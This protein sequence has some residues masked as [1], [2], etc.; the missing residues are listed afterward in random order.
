MKIHSLKDSRYVVV[1]VPEGADI[2]I[3]EDM[4][5]GALFFFFPTEPI[6]TATRIKLP[7]GDYEPLIHAKSITEEQAVGMVDGKFVVESYG[8]GQVYKDYVRSKERG[9]NSLTFDN[10]I[11]SIHSWLTSI[12]HTDDSVILK[13]K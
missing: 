4:T 11:K 10:P 12:G 5:N 1:E 9:A 3:A 13:L 8:H 2:P 7:P 6:R